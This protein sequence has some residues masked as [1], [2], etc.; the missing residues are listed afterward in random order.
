MIKI[1]NKLTSSL[2]A[3]ETPVIN[4]PSRD[5]SI[6][7]STIEELDTFSINQLCRASGLPKPVSKW[8]SNT[9]YLSNDRLI[10]QSGNFSIDDVVN[11]YIFIC[12]AQNSV[13]EDT[14]HIRIRVDID[15]TE[16][17]GN[18]S[19]VTS[20]ILEEYSEIIQRN[21]QGVNYTYEQSS[22]VREVVDRSANNLASLVEKFN[23]T[24]ADTDV[25]ETIL[26]TGDD[27]IQVEL[28]QPVVEEVEETEVT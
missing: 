12:T 20:E 28:Q 5:L 22:V 27:I 14:R 10:I 6:K 7:I 25:L 26:Q 8:T 21:I 2:L 4:E 13:G 19:H 9:D 17:I 1:I 23:D 15:L 11:P 18:L 24:K 3:H 16:I